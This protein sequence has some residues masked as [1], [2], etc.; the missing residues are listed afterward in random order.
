MTLSLQALQ[1]GLL[2]AGW[3]A[4]PG[5]SLA[6]L[7]KYL[8][9]L[10]RIN[11]E[12]NLTKWTSPREV[13]THHVL[14]SAAAL[15]HL[16]ERLQP[17]SRWLDLGTGGGFPGVV[18]LAAQPAASWVFLDSVRKKAKAVEACLQTAGWKAEVLVERAETLGRD[19]RFREQF[20]GVVTRAVA[21]PRVVLEYALP[22]LKV[23]GWFV[24]WATAQQKASWEKASKALETLQGRVFRTAEYTLPG[25]DQTRHLWIVE[26]VGKT[27]EGFPRSPGKPSKN[28]L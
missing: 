17:S 14:D 13:L 2:R 3:G 6:S 26:K 16:Q 5:T 1:E 18:L 24:D 23:G 25:L 12:L 11:E 28:P 9:N 27:P 15:P 19:P 22:L 21:E 7:S 10:L 20:D 4:F 8:E